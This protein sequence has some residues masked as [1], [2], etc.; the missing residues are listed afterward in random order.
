MNHAEA[1]ATLL[2][3]RR[4]FRTEPDLWEMESFFPCTKVRETGFGNNG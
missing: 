4:A 2:D 3:M 1:A